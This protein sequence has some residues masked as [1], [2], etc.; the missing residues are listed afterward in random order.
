MRP[1]FEIPSSPIAINE[2]NLPNKA[3]SSY[4]GDYTA[5]GFGT[6]KIRK[7]DKFLMIDF[8][9]LKL[10]LRHVKDQTFEMYGVEEFPLFFDPIYA[11][12]F[13]TDKNNKIAGFKIY[14]Q[15]IPV[16]F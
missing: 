13:I 5:K 9:E 10:G 11:V 3:L 16:T 1:V 12:K 6:V 2:H 8:P 7:Q 14:L 15:S 4:A